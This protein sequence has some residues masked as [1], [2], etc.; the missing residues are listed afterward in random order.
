M[1]SIASYR[2]AEWC[3]ECARHIPRDLMIDIE[4]ANDLGRSRARRFRRIPL[5]DCASADDSKLQWLHVE[6]QP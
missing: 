6:L 2:R 1:S 4:H 3:L 5:R